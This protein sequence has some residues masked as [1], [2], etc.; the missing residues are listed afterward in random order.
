MQ[1][2][3]VVNSRANSRPGRRGPGG[4]LTRE[5]IVSVAR[6]LIEDEGPDALSMRRLAA[7]VNSSPMALYH[8]V[9]G[10][11]DLLAAIFAQI[12][13]EAPRPELPVDPI[14]RLEVLALMAQRLLH[15]HPWT[16]EILSSDLGLCRENVWYVEEFISAACE[17]G[18]TEKQAAALYLTIWKLV[19]GHAVLC[20]N[21]ETATAQSGIDGVE[22]R[23]MEVAGL[24]SFQK[25][26]DEWSALDASHDLR[27]E[28]APLLSCLNGDARQAVAHTSAT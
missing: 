11:A 25:V 16:L 20:K 2:T 18:C 8:H 26:L 19:I 28:I 13:A 14:R 6:G 15:D 3:D 24:P 12:C 10:R 7:V 4:K 17:A 23:R 22:P 27:A 1:N 9:D 21:R 5:A